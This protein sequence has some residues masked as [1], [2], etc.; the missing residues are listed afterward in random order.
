LAHALHRVTETFR[1]QYPD[2]DLLIL[3]IKR[4]FLKASSIIKILKSIIEIFKSI[5]KLFTNN[6]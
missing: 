3:T 6:Y 5:I 4:I 1:H 2:V